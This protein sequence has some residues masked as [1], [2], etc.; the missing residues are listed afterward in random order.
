MLYIIRGLPGTGKS[1][2]SQFLARKYDAIV[3]SLDDIRKDFFDV[4][5]GV[6]DAVFP[7]E[8]VDEMYADLFASARNLIKQGINVIIDATLYAKTLVDE[9]RAITPES[10]LIQIICPEEETLRRIRERFETSGDKYVAGQQVYEHVKSR[11]EMIHDPDV[12]I[13][14]SKIDPS[15]DLGT[16]LADV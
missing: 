16:Q 9:A 6:K 13:D 10:K 11:T 15:K 7:N 3:L 12:T 5:P 14:T 2:I 8:K 4:D 1:T